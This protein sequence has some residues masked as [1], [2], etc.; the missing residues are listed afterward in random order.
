MDNLNTFGR[1]RDVVVV[2]ARSSELEDY[3]ETAAA[4]QDRYLQSE[5][6]PERGY[7]YRSDH[8]NFAKVGVPALYAESGEDNVEFG[9]EYGAAQA[10]DYTDNRYH[11]PSD[12]YDP[13][14]DLSGAAEDILLYFD[15]ATRLANEQTWPQWYEGNEFKAIRD[16]TADQR[17]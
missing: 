14:W 8:F 16:M 10:Q 3:L 2:G 7:Y 15:I 9:R 12:E 17:P 6:T 4:S 11:A 13:D 5:P 1:T